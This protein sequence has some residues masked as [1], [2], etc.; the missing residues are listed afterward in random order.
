[1][2]L[3]DFYSGGAD[4]RSR[5]VWETELDN[6]KFIYEDVGAGAFGASDSTTYTVPTGKT[7][8]IANISVAAYAINAADGDKQA[9]FKVT[10][11]NVTDSVILANIGGNGGGM[12]PVEVPFKILAG[13]QVKLT[14]QNRSNYVADVMGRLHCYEV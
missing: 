5:A 4:V 2:G 7:L 9:H 12:Y 3:P 11:V 13:E 6:D 1:M 8:Y 10:V 14:V